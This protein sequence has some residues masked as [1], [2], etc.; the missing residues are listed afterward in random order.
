M[1]VIL[2]FLSLVIDS[3]GQG[4]KRRTHSGKTA[5]L[6]E[7]TSQL[8]YATEPF[9]THVSKLPAVHAGHDVAEVYRRLATFDLRKSEFETTDEYRT[10]VKSALGDQL[11]AFE[12]TVPLGSPFSYNA[13]RQ[14]LIVTVP[15]DD[16]F[17]LS[18]CRVSSPDCYARQGVQLTSAIR[19]ALTMEERPKVG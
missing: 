10:R 19:K 6:A 3:Q 2:A 16:S 11:Y 14:V 13:D 15:S 8:R 12:A 18:I 4:A 7:E 17:D 5:K 9:D 1:T